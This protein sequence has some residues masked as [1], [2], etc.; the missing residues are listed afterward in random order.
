MFGWF[1]SGLGRMAAEH[2]MELL[3][4]R[5]D[6]AS[7]WLLNVP[8]WRVVYHEAADANFLERHTIGSPPVI[9]RLE[10]PFATYDEAKAVAD[11]LNAE[12]KAAVRREVE[13]A[14]E[15]HRLP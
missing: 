5:D 3:R 11:T 2:E 7:T 6:R 13:A 4:R 12:L 15:R 8:L 9:E 1:L 14:L 10:K